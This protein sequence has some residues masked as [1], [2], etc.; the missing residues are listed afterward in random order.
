MYILL[1]GTWLHG[2]L[3][4]ASG[5]IIHS[6]TLAHSAHVSRYAYKERHTLLFRWSWV[7]YSPENNRPVSP[8]CQGLPWASVESAENGE[9]RSNKITYQYAFQ[10]RFYLFPKWNYEHLFIKYLASFV[11]DIWAMLVND[12]NAR[13]TLLVRA[14]HTVGRLH[15]IDSENWMMPAS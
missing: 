8:F 7:S 6:Y 5:H 3:R 11:F 4:Q 14:L 1:K 10:Q 2:C 9:V 13:V 12:S 15:K